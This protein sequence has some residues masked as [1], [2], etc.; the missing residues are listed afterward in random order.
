MTTNEA[1]NETRGDAGKHAADEKLEDWLDKHNAAMQWARDLPKGSRSPG[2]RRIE[3]YVVHGGAAI[4]VVRY[5]DGGWGLFTEPNTNDIV[6]TLDDAERRFA[7]K[8]P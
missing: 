4:I 7:P 1:K 3:G 6:E 8:K 5:P 2:P